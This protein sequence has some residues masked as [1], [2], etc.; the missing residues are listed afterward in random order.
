MVM[1]LRPVFFGPP[2]SFERFLLVCATLFSNKVTL[3]WYSRQNELQSMFCLQKVG[4]LSKRLN[5]SGCFFAWEFFSTYPILYYKEIG[6]PAK[7]YFPLEL[8]SLL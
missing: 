3:C 8:F 1:S 7:K 4:V 5:E 2:C 6:V